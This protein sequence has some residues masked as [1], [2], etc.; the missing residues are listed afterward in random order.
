MAMA[1]E[2]RY[3]LDTQ[4][5]QAAIDM[6][7]QLSDLMAEVL[8]WQVSHRG[9]SVMAGYREALDETDRVLESVRDVVQANLQEQVLAARKA[10]MR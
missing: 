10:G 8:E 5:Q 6:G 3:D 7:S 4:K 9:T 1:Q 2:L